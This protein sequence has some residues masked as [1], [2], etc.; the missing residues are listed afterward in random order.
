MFLQFL[1]SPPPSPQYSM[2]ITVGSTPAT[3]PHIEYV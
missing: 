1:T 2:T 3:P